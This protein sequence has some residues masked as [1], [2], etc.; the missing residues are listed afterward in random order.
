MIQA[1]LRRALPASL[2]VHACTALCAWVAA[3][4]VA[5]KVPAAGLTDAPA[6]AAVYSSVRLIDAFFAN[7]YRYAV[8]PVVCL[9]AVT[10]FLRVLWLSAQLNEAPLYA[11]ARSA[12][13]RYR[14][15]AGV[16]ALGIAYTLLAC[17]AGILCA[18]AAMWL[19]SATHNLRLQQ[20]AALFVALPFGFAAFAHAPAVSDLAHAQL[21]RGVSHAWVAIESALS[22]VDARA[23]FMRAGIECAVWALLAFALLAR[24]GLGVSPGAMWFLIVLGQL[25]AALQTA[26]RA[27]WCAWLTEHYRL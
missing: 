22:R 20:C 17:G 21:A 2:A 14:Q 25:C 3:L 4:P 24:L 16:Y 6:A 19:F 5:S 12:Q 1:R 26:L 27:V 11:H 7:P 18:H 8:L 23:C 13:R 10:P 9:A 15:A